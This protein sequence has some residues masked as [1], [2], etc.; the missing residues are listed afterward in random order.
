MD[1]FTQTFGFFVLC[2]F[3]WGKRWKLLYLYGTLHGRHTYFSLK[4]TKSDTNAHTHTR[5]CVWLYWQ[6][7]K[8]E[9]RVPFILAALI[10]PLSLVHFG[11]KFCFLWPD[12]IL[13][14]ERD[15]HPVH[16]LFHECI[17][18]HIQTNCLVTAETLGFFAL[19]GSN[20]LERKSG[21]CCHSYL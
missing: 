21:A 10:L 5:A 6:T 19:S 17:L 1:P 14:W 9:F 20:W 11:K 2:D 8:H 7:L 18:L 12:C 15:N 4:C 16:L 13:S 3:L